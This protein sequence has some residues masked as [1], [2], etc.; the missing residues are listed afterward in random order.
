ML[1]P[2]ALFD[3]PDDRLGCHTIHCGDL[4]LGLNFCFAS[5]NG[6]QAQQKSLTCSCCT[7]VFWNNGIWTWWYTWQ[8]SKKKKKTG[9]LTNAVIMSTI[10]SEM[11]A[12]IAASNS[13]DGHKWC[14]SRENRPQGICRC[15]TKNGRAHHSF[16]MTPTFREYDLWSQKTQILKSRPRPSFFWYDNDKDHKVCFLVT[17]LI[18]VHPENYLLQYQPTSHCK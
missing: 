6:L 18:Y 15:H 1:L 4:V 2:P 11:W 17:R 13:Q 5:A 7:P 12:D 10:Y 3:N 9:F 14:A 16:G 8:Y